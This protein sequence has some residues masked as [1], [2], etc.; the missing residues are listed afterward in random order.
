RGLIATRASIRA[1]WPD[2]QRARRRL[3][4]EGLTVKRDDG[5][6][7]TARQPTAIGR[8][9]H[10]RDAAHRRRYQR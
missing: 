5:M 4:V 3:A 2:T 1:P 10:R 7:R 6:P 9:T 8:A